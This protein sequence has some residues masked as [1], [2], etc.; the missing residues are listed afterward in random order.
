[1]ISLFQMCCIAKAVLRPL[2]ISSPYPGGRRPHPGM[3]E[4]VWPFLKLAFAYDTD[5]PVPS[6]YTDANTA[7]VHLKRV[8]T[9]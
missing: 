4:R 8:E 1:M 9:E 2:P 7:P 3:I 5:P 6:S